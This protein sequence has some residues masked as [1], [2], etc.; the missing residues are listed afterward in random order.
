RA[1]T[2]DVELAT[3]RHE[4]A[5]ARLQ[6]RLGAALAESLRSNYERSRQLMTD[7][8]R[9]AQGRLPAV[10]DPHQRQELQAMLAQRDELITLLARAEPESTQRLMLLYTRFFTAFDPAGVRASTSVTP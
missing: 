9:E 10:E 6:G 5:M 7:F 8:F 1:R 4:L 2:L 3:A